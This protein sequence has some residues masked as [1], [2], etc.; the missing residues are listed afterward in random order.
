M[1]AG[2]LAPWSS[3]EVLEWEV[4]RL[5]EALARI[6]ATPGAAVK[7]ASDALRFAPELELLVPPP[8]RPAGGETAA[9]PSSALEVAPSP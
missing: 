3:R 4:V 5:R 2:E 8:A 1:T 7:I 6:V 9:G